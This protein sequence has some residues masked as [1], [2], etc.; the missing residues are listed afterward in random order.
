MAKD[1]TPEELLKQYSAGILKS[2]ERYKSIISM[3]VVTHHGL[4]VVMPTCAETM[5]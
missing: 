4:T 1:K 3:A 2:I 5:F